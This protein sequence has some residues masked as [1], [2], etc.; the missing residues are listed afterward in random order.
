MHTCCLAICLSTDRSASF[1]KLQCYSPLG[2][3]LTFSTVNRTAVKIL[4]CASLMGVMI[5]FVYFIFLNI[6]NLKYC[7][8]TGKMAISGKNVDESQV[9]MSVGL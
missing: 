7:F 6:L 9:R 5:H 8:H 4:V 3:H 1:F 2:G